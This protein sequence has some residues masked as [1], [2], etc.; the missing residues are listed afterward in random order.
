MKKNCCIMVVL[1]LLFV[2]APIIEPPE[3]EVPD[4]KY[5]QFAEVSGTNDD[6]ED[7]TNFR[8]LAK[9]GNNYYWAEVSGDVLYIKYCTGLTGATNTLTSY[10]VTDGNPA[11]IDTLYSICLKYV[12]HI[13]EDTNYLMA[14]ISFHDDNNGYLVTILYDLDTPQVEATDDYEVT[15]SSAGIVEFLVLDVYFVET[16]NINIVYMY[17]T[18]FPLEVTEV[19]SRE[20]I[21]GVIQATVDFT[22]T[23]YTPHQSD[24][25]YPGHYTRD[26][27][28]GIYRYV[29]MPGANTFYLAECILS[30]GGN[31]YTALSG[32]STPSNSDI[33]H[34]MYYRQKQ[35]EFIIDEDHFY[36][37]RI[38]DSTWSSVSDTGTTTNGIV[39]AYDRDS[40]Y[41]INWIIWKDSIYKIFAGG[42][43]AKIQT[44]TGNAYVGWDD[45]FANGAD[46][47]Y[48][49]DP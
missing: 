25:I 38:G 30:E 5:G 18:D 41:K 21:N 49:L 39:W 32:L 27:T 23:A 11:K 15:S 10:D 40:N 24:A 20:V 7:L 4:V 42:G 26:G 17:H 14:V 16:D 9:F 48:Q 31:S 35:Q 34:Q 1:G 33:S 3:E 29:I 45:W 37:R 47:I 6:L 28:A 13:D 43:V 36:Y 8:N 19:T 44:Y 12:Y 46:K 22:T 2:T